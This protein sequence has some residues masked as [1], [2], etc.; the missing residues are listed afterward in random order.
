MLSGVEL[1]SHRIT[2]GGSPD[3]SQGNIARVFSGKVWFAGPSFIIGAGKSPTAARSFYN[4]Y[5][6]KNLQLRKI[7]VYK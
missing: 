3:A 4:A 2:G 6:T 1:T 5:N 7:L